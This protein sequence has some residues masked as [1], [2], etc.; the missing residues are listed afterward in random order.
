M[1]LAAVTLD[2]AGTVFAPREAVGVTYARVAA[3]HGIALD[4]AATGARFRDALRA[5]PPLAFPGIP[6]DE[7]GSAGRAWWRDVVR[8]AFGAGASHPRFQASFD[9]LWAH[10]AG[11]D[12]WLLAEDAHDTLR[13]LR[14]RGLALGI[15]SNFDG[16]LGDVLA[17]LGVTPLV[18]AVVP[19]GTHD[20]A[21]PDPRLFRA[22]AALLGAPPGALLHV[23]DD[24]EL[25]VRGAL[26]AG[27]RALLL[28]RE[29]GAAPP[30]VRVLRRLRDLPDALREEG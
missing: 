18:D 9:A 17:G 22:A 28:A 12:A 6:P 30:G 25:D 14:A 11:P 5:A 21:K 4:A 23:G 7:R 3:A 8:E 20:F 26:A 15:L 24:V 27:C 29:G 2:A 16:R 1:A 19:S 13:T 10:Y